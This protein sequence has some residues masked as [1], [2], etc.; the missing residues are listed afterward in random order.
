MQANS[1]DANVIQDKS[2]SLYWQKCIYP[3]KWDTSTSTSQCKVPTPAPSSPYINASAVTW[4]Q[5]K[6]KNLCKYYGS[7]W[8]TPTIAELKSLV[9]RSQYN[10]ALDGIF[11]PGAAASSSSSS[12]GNGMPDFFWSS[13]SYGADTNYAWTVNFYYGY[14]YHTS[15]KV[16]NYYL[17]CV[18]NV[19]P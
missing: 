5:V 6:N 4:S 13:T 1:S 8:R 15:A 18:T 3:M 12:S 14:I 11:D 16:N 19:Y 7:N 17:R 9:E 10:P 2:T